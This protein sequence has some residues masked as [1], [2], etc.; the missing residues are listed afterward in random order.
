MSKLNKVH[1]MVS[2]NDLSKEK[3]CNWHDRS[4][5]KMSANAN[6]EETIKN[7]KKNI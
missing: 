5:V 4:S 2:F 1:S 7:I 3:I 6:K